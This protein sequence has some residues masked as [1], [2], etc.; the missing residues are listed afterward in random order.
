MIADLLHSQYPTL[1]VLFMSAFE[2]R[3]VVRRFVKD[4][5][6]DLITKP[7]TIEDLAAKVDEVLA[8]PPDPTPARA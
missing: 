1:R 5:G 8:H 3:Q 6:F 7:F 2:D 4:Q